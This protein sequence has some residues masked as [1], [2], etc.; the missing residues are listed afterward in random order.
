MWLHQG[1]F[2]GSGL[3]IL[4]KLYLLLIDCPSSFP[5]IRE[6][7]MNEIFVLTKNLGKI[8]YFTTKIPLIMNEIIVDGMCSWR[9]W[10]H[11]LSNVLY[12]H[13]VLHAML[14]ECYGNQHGS[15]AQPCHTVYCNTSVR[16]LLECFLY[17][18]QPL[19]HYTRRRGCTVSKFTILQKQNNYDK[20]MRNLYTI[21]R[22]I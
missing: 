12:G 16:L 11:L 19:I 1:A 6:L 4:K 15:P 20:M 21:V 13:V 7:R 9:Y 10:R 18:L 3:V 2:L 8:I 5:I 22:N 17:Q 14:N